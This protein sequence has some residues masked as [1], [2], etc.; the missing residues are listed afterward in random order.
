MQTK[1]GN[2]GCDFT[3]GIGG[4][5]KHAEEGGKRYKTQSLLANTLMPVYNMLLDVKKYLH[6]ATKHRYTQLLTPLVFSHYFSMRKINNIEIHIKSKHDYNLFHVANNAPGRPA[7]PNGLPEFDYGLTIVVLHGNRFRI[8]K[9]EKKTRKDDTPH[10]NGDFNYVINGS[11]TDDRQGLHAICCDMVDAYEYA[12]GHRVT[13][14]NTSHEWLLPKVNM[15]LLIHVYQN[16]FVS[17]D[18]AYLQIWFARVSIACVAGGDSSQCSH[19]MCESS[20]GIRTDDL[21]INNWKNTSY[22][23]VSQN[24]GDVYYQWKRY[25]IATKSD[26][27]PSKSSKYIEITKCEKS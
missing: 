22:A 2:D 11:E 7:H 17:I 21:K 18:I 14:D 26:A 3:F 6:G 23:F 16:P 4:S 15:E 27:M 19:Q 13:S 10:D 5:K 25:R 9:K 12:T 8:I 24:E 1:E 20:R